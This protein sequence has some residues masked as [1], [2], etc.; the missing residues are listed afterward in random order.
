MRTNTLLIILFCLFLVSCRNRIELRPYWD[1]Y[2]RPCPVDSVQYEDDK[3]KFVCSYLKRIESQIWLKE[4][5]PNI[6]IADRFFVIVD[7]ILYSEDKKFMF[8]FY[9]RGDN[10]AIANK[11]VPLYERPHFFHCET[12]IG[13]K[14]S[15]K[16]S[17]VFYDNRLIYNWDNFRDGMDALEYYFLKDFKNEGVIP[18]CGKYGVINYNVNDS[19]FFDKSLLF[20]KFNDS[21]YYFQIEYIIEREYANLTD[22]I[23]LKKSF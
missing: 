4:D 14:D 15:I 3:H 17:L 11:N 18:S 20:K 6:P 12:A 1:A 2:S 9:G 8:V 10:A 5:Y 19:L 13:Y 22:S 7:T 21:L 16:E 23:I